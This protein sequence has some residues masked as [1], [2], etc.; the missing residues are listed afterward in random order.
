M[1]KL[2][3][4]AFA[5]AVGAATLAY[6]QITAECGRGLKKCPSNKPCCSQYGQCGIGAF[7]LGGC[8]PVWSSS[9][10]AC[11]PIPVCQSKKFTF[12]NM[13]NIVDKSRYL[14]DSS[15]FDWVADGKP[16]QHDDYVL[17]TMPPKSVGT[18]LSS[19]TEILYGKVSATMRTSRGAGVVTAFILFSD[20]KDEIDY[21]WVGTELNTAQTNYYWQGVTNYANGGNVSLSDTFGTWHTYEIDWTPESITWKIDGQ[22]GRVKKRSD[23]YNE[24][25]KNYDYPQTPSR[26]Q[27]SIWPG[28]LETNGKGTIDWAGGPIRWDHEDIKTV[29]YYYATV[30]DVTVECYEPP[31]S[32]KKS[33]SKTYIYTKDSGLEGDVE[34]TD[35]DHILKSFLG[36]G[37]DMDKAPASTSSA[38]GSKPTE[39]PIETVPGMTGAG[40]SSN[41]IDKDSIVN[42]PSSADQA[43][44]NFVQKPAN[45]GNSS[46]A[47]QDG[48]KAIFAMAIAMIAVAFL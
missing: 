19:T 17:L 18:V 20:V 29:G 37:L 8:D 23:T 16:L 11:V 22:V 35:K 34:I 24:K 4:V 26:V 2:S 14:G 3:T 44:K 39:A 45:N 40:T 41:D 6:A 36:S 7:C 33:G 43:T 15:K 46:G 38:P 1:V 13:N 28:G 5:T 27:L 48:A 21:E 10:D 12:T 42:M 9:V 47:P 32:V 25:T 31:K 30:K